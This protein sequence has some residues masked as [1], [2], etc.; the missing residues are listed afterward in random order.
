VFLTRERPK[1]KAG[2]RYRKQRKEL[3][4]QWLD[5]AG[6]EEGQEQGDWKQGM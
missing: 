1:K 5:Q 3:W 2:H 4:K 6:K